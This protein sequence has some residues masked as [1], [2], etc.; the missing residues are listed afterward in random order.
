MLRVRTVT[1]TF[2]W[3]LLLASWPATAVFAQAQAQSQPRLE[4]VE[5]VVHVFAL[6][7]KPATEALGK[8]HSLLSPRGSIEL[9]PREN[10]L[11]IRDSRAALSRIVTVLRNFDHPARPMRL[12]VLIVKATRSPVSP[13]I[14]RSDLPEV[15][16]QRLRSMLPFDI[17]ELQARAHLAALEGQEV[18]YSMSSEYGLKFSFGTLT[19]DGKIKLSSFRLS[20]RKT[21]ANGVQS[22]SNLMYTNLNLRLDETAF[23]AVSRTAD[24][25]EA[26]TL[27]LTP[28]RGGQAGRSVR[29]EP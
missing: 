15:L 16:T 14:Q 21:G 10:T 12:E 28:R 26:I 11:V 9:Q 19:P 1:A 2:L 24:S 13:Q 4:E 7:H 5:V 22:S 17:F 27:V 23:V 20:R 8:I 18:N 3:I 29:A 25:P 6:K